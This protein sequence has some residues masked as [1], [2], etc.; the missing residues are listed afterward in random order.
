MI[1]KHNFKGKDG[2]ERILALD[3]NDTTGKVQGI[4]FKGKAKDFQNNG[5]FMNKT[6]CIRCGN[7]FLDFFYDIIVKKNLIFN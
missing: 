6:K 2:D 1:I 7:D 4:K 3:V 5:G